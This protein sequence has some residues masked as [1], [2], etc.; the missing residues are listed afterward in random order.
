MARVAAQLSIGVLGSHTTSRL[1]VVC[2]YSGKLSKPITGRLG[3]L[4]AAQHTT[5][6]TIVC[7]IVL[8]RAPQSN[9]G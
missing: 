6:L 7:Q 4:I 9:A 5:S 2:K 1:S 8:L 3:R